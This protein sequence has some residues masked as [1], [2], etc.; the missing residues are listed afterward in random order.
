M[1]GI[2]IST[3]D[4]LKSLILN[5]L[6]ID[7]FSIFLFLL[8]LFLF[9]DFIWG[10]LINILFL[11]TVVILLSFNSLRWLIIYC[12]NCIADNICWFVFFIWGCIIVEDEL[13]SILYLANFYLFN[14]LWSPIFIIALFSTTFLIGGD[15]FSTKFL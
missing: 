6:I 12:W 8:N 2:I 13:I 14:L 5:R 4:W 9:F 7:F 10:I 3:T 11:I 1:I 15:I